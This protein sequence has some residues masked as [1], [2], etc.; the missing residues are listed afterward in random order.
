ML[1]ENPLAP[2]IRYRPFRV[3]LRVRVK[4]P[5]DINNKNEHLQSIHVQVFVSFFV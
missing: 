3:H 2:R 4:Y 1:T 5:V